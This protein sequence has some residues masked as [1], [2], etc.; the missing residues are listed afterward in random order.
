MHLPH[1]TSLLHLDRIGRFMSR[2]IVVMSAMVALIVFP[3]MLSAEMN[4]SAWFDI[5]LG[6]L[7]IALVCPL[8]LCAV[9]FVYSRRLTK[10]D[11]RLDSDV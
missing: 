10:V 4:L 6:F 2:K 1:I 8:L 9:V 7:L 11:L 5:P 3:Y